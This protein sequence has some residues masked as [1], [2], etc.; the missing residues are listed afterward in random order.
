MKNKKNEGYYTTNYQTEASI[1]K[2]K[3]HI[4]C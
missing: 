3:E 1:N 2:K 4:V